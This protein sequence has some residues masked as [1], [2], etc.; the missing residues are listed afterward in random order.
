MYVVLSYPRGSNFYTDDLTEAE[1][2]YQQKKE[3]YNLAAIY[4]G[5]PGHFDI[6]IKESWH[7]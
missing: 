3:T 2:V 4:Q 5:E 7:K 1:E 6:T